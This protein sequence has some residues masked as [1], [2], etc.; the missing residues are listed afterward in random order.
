M[1]ASGVFGAS[2]GHGWWTGCY[3]S[4][5]HSQCF[6]SQPSS[7][8]GSIP[9][10]PRS[11]PVMSLAELWQ[12]HPVNSFVEADIP[13]LWVCSMD[14]SVS[15]AR[16]LSETPQQGICAFGS[17]VTRPQK[18]KLFP[19]KIV[20][21]SFCTQ[22]I[23]ECTGLFSTAVTKREKCSEQHVSFYCKLSMEEDQCLCCGDHTQTWAPQEAGMGVWLENSG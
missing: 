21:M 16:C 8:Q 1:K 4:P 9:A 13:L 10:H 2:T 12:H 22:I 19:L 15:S 3:R 20:F 7:M 14:G 6:P 5:R 23:Y 11:S 17:R 18:R